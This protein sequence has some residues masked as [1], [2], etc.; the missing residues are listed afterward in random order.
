MKSKVKFAVLFILVIAVL[1]IV[2]NI[3][4]AATTAKDE[5]SLNSAIQSVEEGGTVELQG[6]ITVTKPI[7][8]QKELIIDG[9]GYTVS[10][11]TE[12]TS[13]SGNQSMFT[14]QSTA[15]KL[16][17]KD[18]DLN[19]GPKYGVQSYDGASVILNNVSITNFRY[20]GVL[21]NGGYVEVIDLHLGYNGTGANNGI[22]IDKGAY[23]TNNP[24]LV[25]NGTL[26]SDTAENVVRVAE[27]G[28]LTSFI[29]SNTESTTNKIFLAGDS[30][31][32]TDENN[33]IVS[34]TTVPSKVTGTTTGKKQVILTII[35]GDETNRITV[36]EGE[37]I[38]EDIIKS[39]ISVKEGYQ[40]DG[41]FTD[42]SFTNSFDFNSKLNADTT[43][44][45]RTSKIPVTP[46]PEPEEEEK[47][48]VPNT[49]TQDY[50]G[51]AVLTILF[52]LGSMIIISRKK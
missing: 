51:I 9:N 49:G 44:Y 8:I 27:N 37:S 12:W 22:E 31:V 14:A 6:N 47:D 7:A 36:T 34:E 19:N 46:E 38:T 45:V 21:V 4:N 41:Y 15:G 29:I 30:L 28:N 39:N 2:P 32:L 33:N 3:S 13:T 23:A 35:N 1:L 43:I 20:G 5:E 10:G 42:E 52:A 26:T 11:S 16:T 40:I 48:E 50:T 25:M 24:T 17:L 18:I